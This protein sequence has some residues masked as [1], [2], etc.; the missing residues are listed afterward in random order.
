MRQKCTNA[1]SWNKYAIGKEA[2][3]IVRQLQE[4]KQ[5]ITIFGSDRSPLPNGQIVEVGEI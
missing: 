4:T 2:L 3:N 5:E 1:D